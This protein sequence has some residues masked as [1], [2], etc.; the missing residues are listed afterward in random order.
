M[1]SLA[2]YVPGDV[3][4]A[5]R[6]YDDACRAYDKAGFFS[7]AGKL[8]DKGIAFAK[9]EGLQAGLK[10]ANGVLDLA[11]NVVNG[12][13]YS[14]AKASVSFYEGRLNDA[15]RI[16]DGAIGV[17]GSTLE[18]TRNVQNGLVSGAE[19]AL[20]TVKTASKELQNTKIT[21][22]ILD[23][24]QAAS[25]RVL[26]GL[27]EAVNVLAQCAEKVAFDTADM[28][29]KVAR[30]NVKDIDIAKAAVNVAKEGTEAVLDVGNWI[31]QHAFNIL[32]IR[33]L[34]LKGDLRGFAR[35]ERSYSCIL[36]A[37]LPS[38]M[39]TSLSTS[40]PEREKTL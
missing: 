15:R 39:L 31:V 4:N 9:L 7:K 1:I 20:N 22:K 18:T 16:A 13:G 3:N 29:L 35:R 17:A 36:W 2:D 11:R 28:G 27:Q 14:A 38:R 24:F 25:Q 19:G 40:R 30:A 21:Q 33:L 8:K 12:P 32:N 6:E 23:D 37:R 26:S 5:R 10:I 34:E